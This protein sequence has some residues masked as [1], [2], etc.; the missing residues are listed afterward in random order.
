MAE[1]GSAAGEETGDEEE[2]EEKRIVTYEAADRGAV[3]CLGCQA[4]V[5]VLAGVG[6][7][8][9]YATDRDLW[10]IIV[11][12]ILLMGGLT[13]YLYLRKRNRWEVTFDRDR[14]VVTLFSSVAGDVEKR[15][16]DFDRIEAVSLREI[17]RDVTTGED[18]PHQLPVFHLEAGEEVPLDQRLSIKD[19]ERAEEVADEMRAL[20]GLSQIAS[21]AEQSGEDVCPEK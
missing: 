8:I 17:T 9:W 15:E 16:I 12:G 14:Q 10:R 4:W 20:L 6:F 5:L 21:E 7:G 2:T 11:A 3:C 18:V 1:D 13:L 19:S